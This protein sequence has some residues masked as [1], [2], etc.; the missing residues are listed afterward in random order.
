MN[1]L[2][3]YQNAHS[4][5]GNKV[6]FTPDLVIISTCPMV[7]KLLLVRLITIPGC[8]VRGLGI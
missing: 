2:S 5:S 6:E 3:I 4:G 8:G 1:L 7:Q